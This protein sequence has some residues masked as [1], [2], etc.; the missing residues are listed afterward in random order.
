MVAVDMYRKSTVV[1]SANGLFAERTA[2]NTPLQGSAADII[3]DVMVALHQKLRNDE[4][5]SR[6]ILQVHDELILN[7][8][9]D[10]LD[11]V[12]PL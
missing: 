3:K 10:E 9:K 1:I 7:C 8:P 12:I 6:I 11:S 5:Q 4:L 2:M